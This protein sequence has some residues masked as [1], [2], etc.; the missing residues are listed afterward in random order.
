M[1]E[2][3]AKFHN[4]SASL[5]SPSINPPFF[6]FHKVA[7]EKVGRSLFTVCLLVMSITLFSRGHRSTALPISIIY[8]PV[9]SLTSRGFRAPVLRAWQLITST[10]IT[11]FVAMLNSQDL[12][13]EKR[14]IH[15]QFRN[16][17]NL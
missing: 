5:H 12:S 9:F 11:F 16:L 2:F 8:I 4:M 6:G 14:K 13:Q 17:Q 15:L 3:R 1:F 10:A 7:I